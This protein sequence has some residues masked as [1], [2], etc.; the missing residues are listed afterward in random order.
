MS[1]S[2]RCALGVR[3]VL[4]HY[5]GQGQGQGEKGS[6]SNDNG[7]RSRDNK[8]SKGKGSDKGRNS[9][10]NGA[11][12]SSSSRAGPLNGALINAALQVLSRASSALRSC[13]VLNTSKHLPLTSYLFYSLTPS[14]FHSLTSLIPHLFSLSLFTHPPTPPTHPPQCCATGRLIQPTL[15]LL[16]LI[17]QRGTATPI[18]SRTISHTP[19]HTPSHIPSTSSLSRTPTPYRTTTPSTSAAT[20]LR[21][22][23]L[24][25]AAL[26][27]PQGA[28]LLPAVIDLLTGSSCRPLSPARGAL[29]AALGAAVAARHVAS[30]QVD[31]VRCVMCELCLHVCQL[32][33]VSA[34][35]CGVR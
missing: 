27:T 22:V 10:T 1:V 2:E 31:D 15:Q 23:R 12:S 28:P 3:L 7:S 13:F 8:N 5:Q 20:D 9:K 34:G 25:C 16:A 18:P 11:A 24:I 33:V 17:E 14:P 4:D 35:G 19:S 21:E 29:V 32:C 26:A 6:S 30:A